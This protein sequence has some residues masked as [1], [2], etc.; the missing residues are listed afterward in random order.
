MVLRRQPLFTASTWRFGSH[1]MSA[2]TN[3]HATSFDRK[4]SRNTGASRAVLIVL[5]KMLVL[6]AKSSATKSIRRSGVQEASL[7]SRRRT[8]GSPPSPMRIS[9]WEIN[10]EGELRYTM[11][12]LEVR[13]MVEICYTEGRHQK[14]I[15]CKRSQTLN[16]RGLG[17]LAFVPRLDDKIL[18][19]KSFSKNILYLYR[20]LSQKCERLSNR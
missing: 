6:E 18:V 3:T 9:S 15:N 14:R 13:F 5:Y 17:K 2:K 7:F 1:L 19:H 16:C 11:W 4:A 20:I 12:I 8:F 10:A